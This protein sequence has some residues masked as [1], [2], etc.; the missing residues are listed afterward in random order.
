MRRGLR[1]CSQ[2][3]T[4]T[5]EIARYS[6]LDSDE[7]FAG[8]REAAERQ[9]ATYCI[10]I[11]RRSPTTAELDRIA[12]VV[13]R[14]K[15]AFGLN[16]CTSVGLLSSEQA[17]RLKA[18][19]VDRVNHNLN[20]SRR[21]YPE[22]CTTHS[23]DDRMETLRAVRAAGLDVCSG[24]SSAWAR[25]MRTSWNLPCSLGSWRRSPCRSTS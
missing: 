10:V 9:A 11:A 3:G 4:A 13:P 25:R 2:A 16:I 12:E 18:C 23:Y 8:A 15:A 22:I 21:F 1:Y 17:A 24:E 20:T 19:G 7:I 5:A 6:M 14:I